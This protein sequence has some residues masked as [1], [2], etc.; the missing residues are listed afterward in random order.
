MPPI[1]FVSYN[2]KDVR[3]K[4]R[5][6]RQLAVLEREGLLVT[7]HDG[8]IQAGADWLPEIEAAIA[9]AR[10]AVL[11]ISADSLNSDFIRGREIPALIERRLRD[12]LRVIPLI[13]DACAWK[14][15]G[16]LA[17]IQAR[18]LNDKTLAE[19]GRAKA[20]RVLAGLAEEILKIMEGTTASSPSSVTL[21][22]GPKRPPHREISVD[23]VRALAKETGIGPLVG[24]VLDTAR[25]LQLY[26]RPYRRSVMI[27]PPKNHTRMLFTIWGEGKDGKVKMYVGHSPFAE[28]FPVTERTA[29]RFLG[30]YGWRWLDSR[31]IVVFLTGLR[32]LMTRIDPPVNSPQ[33]S[34]TRPDALRVRRDAEKFAA[35]SARAVKAWKTRRRIAAAA[36]KTA[37]KSGPR[38]PAST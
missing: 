38:R 36:A 22:H 11:I 14:R 7:W 37:K 9:S 20:E 5:L 21:P 25:D 15:V 29:A 16:W 13:A 19:L 30:K 23:A 27:T 2:H 26:L 12:G 4:E 32:K 3:W 28:Y 35:D 17:A 1:A 8:L 33:P 18:P 6:G 31:E 10:V 24:L 34:R